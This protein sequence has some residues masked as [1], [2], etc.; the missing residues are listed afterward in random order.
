MLKHR[1]H[2][3]DAIAPRPTPAPE[4]RLAPRPANDQD[5]PVASAARVLQADIAKAFAAKNGW[6]VG[7]TVAAGVVFHLGVFCALGLAAGAVLAQLARG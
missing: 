4:P 1:T 7:R 3:L 6:S 5:T 2:Y